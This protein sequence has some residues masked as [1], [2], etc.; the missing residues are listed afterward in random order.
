MLR[1]RFPKRTP[2]GREGSLLSLTISGTVGSRYNAN[3][4]ED[5]MKTNVVF[6]CTECGFETKKWQG[7]CNECGNWNSLIEKIS[8]FKKQYASPLQAIESV[9]L[10][11]IDVSIFS[12]RPILELPLK[13]VSGVMKKA[14]VPGGLL[15]LGGEP[16]IGKSTLALQFACYLQTKQRMLY[17]SGEETL[18]QL[19]IRAER[20]SV[21]KELRCLMLSD[22]DMIIDY[23]QNEKELPHIVVIDSL[24]VL[25]STRSAGSV[26]SVA[27]IKYSVDVLRRIAKEKNL[28]IITIGHITKDGDIAGPKMLEHMVDAVFYLEGERDGTIRFL[29]AVKNRFDA[30]N[31]LGIVEMTENGFRD[32]A[33]PD[34]IFW[35]QEKP[36]IGTALGMIR[37][38]KRIFVT[39]VQAL[40]VPTDFGYPRRTSLGY[41]LN[42]LHTVLAVLQRQLDM[43]FNKHDV[44]IKLKAGLQTEDTTLD[45]AVALAL[46]SSY[47]KKLVHEHVIALGEI[48]LNGHVSKISED[49]SQEAK[50]RGLK[51]LEISHISDLQKIWL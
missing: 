29:R 3:N 31:T 46:I 49:Y 19:R 45:T 41:D 43:P 22:V 44:Y 35:Q 36:E 16:G 25:Y 12:E 2:L 33:N 51:F 50:K 8:S 37:Q 32:A 40:V 26:G 23:L 5:S 13:E 14:L 27:Q 9:A 6:S 24:H 20:L 48:T 34:L 10:V 21:S 1:I 7:R 11:D 17:I 4:N 18:A 42:R 39:E 47:Q 38:G 30:V 28:L 15:L